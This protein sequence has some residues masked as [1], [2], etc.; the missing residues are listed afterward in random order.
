MTI[1]KNISGNATVNTIFRGRKVIIKPKCSYILDD[2][3][4]GKAEA[5]FLKQAYGFV[6]DVTDL[7]RPKE[8]SDEKQSTIQQL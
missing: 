4:E 1:L 8:V 6:L 2:T 5:N 3:E 7:V